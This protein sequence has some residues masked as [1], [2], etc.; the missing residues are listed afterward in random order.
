M[1]YRDFSFQN[2]M[3]LSVWLVGILSSLVSANSTTANFV[4]NPLL[5]PERMTPR[6]NNGS[7]SHL[8]KEDPKTTSFEQPC[9][10]RCHIIITIKES[11]PCH[12]H[13]PLIRN[14]P[15]LT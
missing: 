4:S 13:F 9:L 6:Q 3:Q 8:C 11:N 12:Y 7:G 14:E 1:F 10:V 15:F 5:C 2:S